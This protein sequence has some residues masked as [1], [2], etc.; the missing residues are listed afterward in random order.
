MTAGDL[1]GKVETAVR[2]IGNG[3]TSAPRSAK[4]LGQAAKARKFEVWQVED[5]QVKKPQSERTLP[6]E[7]EGPPQPPPSPSK[8][9]QRAASKAAPPPP[10]ASGR[11]TSG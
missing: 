1:A 2:R 6:G 7:S 10:G 8:S 5:K 3:K 9:S 4:V 11:K